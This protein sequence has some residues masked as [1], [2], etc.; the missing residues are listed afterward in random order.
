MPELSI[1]LVL[2]IVGALAFD[3]INGFH[4]TANAIATVV[5]TRVLTPLQAVM[6]AAV[7]N[8]AGA[9]VATHVAKTIAGGIVDPT[10]ATEVVV[11]A[12]VVGAIGWNLITWVY[13]I[14]S[15]SS[16]ALIGGLLGAA[17][18][19]GGVTIVTWNGVVDKV[20]LPLV[21][22]PIV[23]FFVAFLVMR[24]IAGFFHNVHPGKA[25]GA[26]RKLQLVSSALMAFS[27][28]QNDAQKSMGIITLALVANGMLAQPEVPL[29]VKLACATAMGFGTAAGGWRI[30]KTLGHKIIR[31]EPVHGFA[32]ETSGAAV[33]LAASHFG[34]PISTTHAI[35]ASIF[36]VG[37]SK[38][39]S[40]VRWQVARGVVIAWVITIPA[41]AAF[42]AVC[43]EVLSLFWR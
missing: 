20:I 33:I 14:P 41:T 8:V 24:L 18:A 10:Q 43:F 29:W 40:A 39:I 36:G 3:Y 16:H 13:G 9:M 22:S 19:K 7:L 30:I 42:G 27:H 4:D 31:L 28:G 34:M 35:T 1:L 6:M 12:A 2:V 38:R 25:G 23:G 32:A 15:S 11:L 21:G 37:A 5:S 26:F 17:I